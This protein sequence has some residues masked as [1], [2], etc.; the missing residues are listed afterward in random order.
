MSNTTYSPEVSQRL[1][2][3]QLPTPLGFG[4]ELAPVMFRADYDNNQWSAGE[5]VPFANLEINPGATCV[6]FGQQCFEGMKAYKVAQSS[7]A[8]FRPEVNYK[9]FIRSATR[10]CMPAPPES[11]FADALNSVSQA[12]SPFVPSESGQSL[13]LRPT[14]I[15]M[16]QTFAVTASQRYCFVLIASPSDAYYT[17]PIKI[18]IERQQSRAAKGGTGSEKVGGNYAGSLQATQRCID[19]GFDQPLWL[20]A[21]NHELVEELSGMNF[22]AVIG[23][24]LH[25][26]KLSGTILPGITRQSIIALAK[27]MGIEVFERDIPINTLQEDITSGKCSELFACGTAAIISPIS[28]LGEA[29]GTR[30][31]LPNVD[32]LASRLRNALLDIQEGR[33][34]DS[35]QWMVDSADKDALL[36]RLTAD[37]SE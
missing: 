2:S 33:A 37:T 28:E 3:Y 15:G 17:Q 35:H 4:K 24:A 5:L 26:P 13:Y 7:P 29:D 14:L 19:A 1:E 12:M 16:D 9:R 11:L 22:M 25:T 34:E 20:D 8:L 23:G 18:M 32:R 21:A 27:S 36:A 6:Q 30:Q 10:L 31:A